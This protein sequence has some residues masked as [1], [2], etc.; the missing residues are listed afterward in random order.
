MTNRMTR[1]KA[2][3]LGG[4]ALAGAIAGAGTASA[5]TDWF[6]LPVITANVG[7]DNLGARDAAFDAVRN[8]DG[9]NRPLVCFQEISEGDSGEEEMIDHYFGPLYTK[10]FLRHETSFRVPICVGRP[11]IVVSSRTQRA[12]GGITGVTPPRWFNEVIVRHEDHPSIEFAVLNTHYIAN[13]YNGDQ[14][15]DLRDEWWLM[16]DIHRARSRAH[17]DAGRLVI[18]GADTNRPD[19]GTAS[20][21]SAEQKAFG[22]GI[23]RLHWL[24][25]D[26]SV[27]ITLNTTRTIDMNVDSHNARLAIFH[28]RAV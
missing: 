14:R 4:G 3:A 2:L 10:A 16:R 22:T 24:P 27:Q 28:V 1:R 26:G 23:D 9:D 18:W 12:H 15:T 20:D 17:H 21:L 25:G 7:R 5:A 13:A 8:A 11:W 19:F 6:R